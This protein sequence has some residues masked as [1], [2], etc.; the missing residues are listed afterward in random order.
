MMSLCYGKVNEDT[1]RLA[2]AREMIAVR[3]LC[4]VHIYFY[5]V[6]TSAEF[7]QYQHVCCGFYCFSQWR[8]LEIV[9]H[10]V[11]VKWQKW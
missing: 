11:T 3:V 5:G 8:S 1:A 9:Q 4:S 7:N 10:P 6:F 2:L